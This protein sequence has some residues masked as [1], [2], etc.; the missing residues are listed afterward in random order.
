[1]KQYI[2]LVS[3]LLLTIAA[4]AQNLNPTVQVT[5]AYEGKLLE[6]EKQNVSMAVPDSLTQFDWKFNYSVFDNPY[7]GAYEFNPYVIEMRPDPVPFDGRNLYVRAGLGY[8]LHPEAQLV[9]TPKTNGQF[10]ISIYDD[11]KGYWG[12][13]HQIKG[14]GNP[15]D[16]FTLKS[17]GNYDGMDA[18][19][20]FGVSTSLATKPVIF[21]LDGNFDWLGARMDNDGN[22][23]LG[24]GAALRART[25]GI[26]AFTFDAAARIDLMKNKAGVDSGNDF[27]ERDLGG[28]I[29]LKYSLTDELS[30]G[31]SGKYDH[32]MFTEWKGVQDADWLNITPMVTYAGNRASVS[33]GFKFSDVWKDYSLDDQVVELPQGI[34]GLA[35]EFSPADYDGRKLFPQLKA[36]Y[37]LAEDVLVVF[38][39]ITGGQHF[40]SYSSFLERNHYLPSSLSNQYSFCIG[41]TS[42]NT[43]DGSL[44]FRGKITSR[45]QYKIDA[46]YARWLN[47]P[48]EGVIPAAEEGLFTFTHSMTDFALKY[49]DLDLSWKSDR[50][51]ASAS[52]RY[53]DARRIKDTDAETNR[54]AEAFTLPR[55]KGS[56]DFTYNW[57]RRVFAG[58]FAEWA[59]GRER[60]ES[61]SQDSEVRCTAPGW[62]DLGLSLEFKVNNRF[63]AW[64]NGGNLLNQT[65]MRNLLIAQK[66][67]YVT[68]GVSMVF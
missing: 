14:A 23:A 3:G 15:V 45:V 25:N 36:S 68:A 5:N 18:G 44:G 27:K 56:V 6:V 17:A 60:F 65:I 2:T 19:N 48:L 53:Q 42:V 20:R 46:G 57:N 21:S 58:V 52:L 11:F 59:T 51:D 34:D 32:F 10:G 41:D 50:I 54:G 62:V 8:T 12:P 43:F 64:L 30:F 4:S 67:L 9:W 63:S 61:L 39:G 26:H 37:E 66:G 29:S 22:N 13:Y 49:A 33:A 24:G 1:M 35:A 47:V 31:L 28:D 40:N 55:F 7:K 38:A 16:G